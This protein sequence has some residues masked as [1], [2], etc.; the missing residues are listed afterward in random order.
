MICENIDTQ[1]LI[2]NSL[3]ARYNIL[4]LKNVSLFCNCIPSLSGITV[5]Y[6]LSFNAWL[7]FSQLRIYISKRNISRK[8]FNER[9][10]LVIL[11]RNSEHNLP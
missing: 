4:K 5:L 3:K 8:G 10:Q 2:E 1:Y 6:V 9:T 7:P 11:I